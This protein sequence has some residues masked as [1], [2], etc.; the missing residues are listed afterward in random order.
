MNTFL[1][2]YDWKVEMKKTKTKQTETYRALL[3]VNKYSALIFAS[4]VKFLEKNLHSIMITTF[5][6]ICKYAVV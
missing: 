2:N 3:K 1:F 6:P 4:K 5:K